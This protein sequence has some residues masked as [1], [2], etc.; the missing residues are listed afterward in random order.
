MYS[1]HFLSSAKK[2]F[3]K[4]DTVIQ[5]LIKEKLL[6]LVENPEL[7]KNNIKPLKGEYKGKF[8][9]RVNQY[10]IVF[11]IKDEELIIIIVRIGHRKEIY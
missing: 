2:E 10:R 8:R 4:L 11:Q 5:K 1:L 7:L 3:A 9:L 6:L